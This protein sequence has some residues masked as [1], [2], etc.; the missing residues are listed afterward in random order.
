MGAD[1]SHKCVREACH[2]VAFLVTCVVSQ[3]ETC[4]R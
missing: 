1:C 4:Q 2:V 3:R